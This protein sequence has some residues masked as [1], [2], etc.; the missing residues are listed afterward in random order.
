MDKRP[1]AVK[2]PVIFQLGNLVATLIEQSS[3]QIKSPHGKSIGGHYN[4]Q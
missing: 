1:G 4:L 2:L 3:Q